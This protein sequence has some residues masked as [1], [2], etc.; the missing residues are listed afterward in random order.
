[1]E[2]YEDRKI[3]QYLKIISS[4]R[5]LVENQNDKTV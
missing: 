1:M 5:I 3:I 2:K 4:N